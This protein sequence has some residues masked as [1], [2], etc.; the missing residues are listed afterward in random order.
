[1]SD[2]VDRS[3]WATY[4]SDYPKITIR[5]KKCKAK[6]YYTEGLPSSSVGFVDAQRAMNEKCV[7]TVVMR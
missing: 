4:D 1:M 7:C 6:T 5:C 2:I 3:A